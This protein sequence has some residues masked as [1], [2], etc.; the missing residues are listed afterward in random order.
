MMKRVLSVALLASVLAGCNEIPK[1]ALQLTPQ[2]IEDRK[3]QSRRF[4][5]KDMTQILTSSVGVVQDL[6]F[7]LEESE[8]DLGVVVG[9][10]DRSATDAGQVTMAIAIALL[11][12]G[13]VPIDHV[14]KMRV[15]MVAFPANDG[16]ETVV[17][18][19]FQRLVWDNRGNLSKLEG[20]KDPEVYKEFFSKL[21]KSMFLEANE[22]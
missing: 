11:G 18:V 1:E 5:T 12:G 21:S 8:S 10:K 13:S 2:S 16:K 7:T 9:T 15:S 22:V 4:D 20:I 6:G 14:Q 17:R 19:T 3:L